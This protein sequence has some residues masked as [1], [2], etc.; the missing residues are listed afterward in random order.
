MSQL[1]GALAIDAGLAPTDRWERIIDTIT[2][3]D[4]LVIRSWTGSEAGEYSI[5]KMLKQSQGIYEI[6]WE[7]NRQIVLAEPF[8]SYTVHDAVA[9]AGKAAMLPDLLLRWSQFLV[10]GYDTI[11]ECWGWGTHVHGWSCTPT[12]DLVFYTL[13]VMPAEPGYAVARI[14]PRL[15]RLRWAKGKV[16]TPYGLVAVEASREKVVVDSPVPIVV[17]LEGV[18]PLSLPPGRHEVA[19]AADF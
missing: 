12:R 1:A 3:A 16:P 11:G 15:G 6:D 5:H 9:A 7:T 10:N 18:P 19:S 13:G 2:D 8:M 14:A 4:R 17:E